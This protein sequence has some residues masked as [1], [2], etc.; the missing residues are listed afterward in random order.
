[1][2]QRKTKEKRM[3]RVS[4]FDLS[5]CSENCWLNPPRSTALLTVNLPGARIVHGINRGAREEV[6]KETAGFIIS[7]E[8]AHP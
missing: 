8:L 3:K 5:A 2:N 4:F 7:D 6:P 1:V